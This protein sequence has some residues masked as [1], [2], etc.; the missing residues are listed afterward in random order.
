MYRCQ[1]KTAESLKWCCKWFHTTEGCKN[2]NKFKLMHYSI[3]LL[4]SI[5]QFC[6]EIHYFTPLWSWHPAFHLHIQLGCAPALPSTNWSWAELLSYSAMES[7]GDGHWMKAPEVGIARLQLIP[8]PSW[9]IPPPW[10]TWP[11]CCCLVLGQAA[12]ACRKKMKSRF[13]AAL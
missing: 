12:C 7:G 8:D 10:H 11:G 4:P 6:Y 3:F 1:R 9:K 5:K 13:G 2:L